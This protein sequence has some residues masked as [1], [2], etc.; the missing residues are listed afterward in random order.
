MAAEPDCGPNT[1]LRDTSVAAWDAALSE[2]LSG[3]PH[4]AAFSASVAAAYSVEASVDPQL[5]FDT[6]ASDYGLTC[7]NV[8]LATAAVTT[9]RRKAPTYVMYNAWPRR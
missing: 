4:G 3:W 1:V 2:A 8:A 7:A 5:A 9:G 6:L